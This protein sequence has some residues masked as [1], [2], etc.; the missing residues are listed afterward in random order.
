MGLEL[1]TASVVP[2][3][4]CRGADHEPRHCPK[5]RSSTGATTLGSATCDWPPIVRHSAR[6]MLAAIA[7]AARAK[8][9]DGRPP[10][11]AWESART[12]PVATR[13]GRVILASLAVGGRPSPRSLG[14]RRRGCSGCSGSTPAPTG[15]RRSTGSS[16]TSSTPPTAPTGCCTATA[17]RSPC[18]SP[19]LRRRRAPRAARGHRAGRRQRVPPP[20]LPAGLGAGRLPPPAGALAG[21][22]RHPPHRPGRRAATRR[23]RRPGPGAPRPRLRYADLGRHDDAHLH[24]RRALELSAAVGDPT[25]QA[26]THSAATSCMGSRAVTATPSTTRNR[27]CTCSRPPATGSGRR[28]RSATSAGTTA[29][30]ATTGPGALPAGTDP[31]PGARQPPLSG[32][33]VVLPRRH[34]PAPRQPIQG[35]RLLPGRRRPLPGGLGDRYGEASTLAQ[36][37]EVHRGVG[38]QARAMSGSASTVPARPLDGLHRSTCKKD[39]TECGRPCQRARF[40]LPYHHSIP[41]A[42]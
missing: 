41:A 9:S 21:P 15:G 2:R 14:P 18:P 32:P 23:P 33:H 35:R 3:P 31:A 26:W 37:G 10:I 28:S 42:Q 8:K 19:T 1:P 4:R 16:T 12:P 27:P 25:G 24:F 40:A 17:R 22:G 30:S 36:L 38:R 6:G 5:N 20:R 7:S 39:S 13:V 34:P 11:P 29:G